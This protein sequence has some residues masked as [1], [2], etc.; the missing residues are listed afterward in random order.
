[1]SSE[2]DQDVFEITDFT[3][4]S[5][6][7]RF[8]SRIEEVFHEWKLPQHNSASP[9]K[10][11]ELTEG[12]WLEKREQLMFASFQFEAVHH[13]LKPSGTT[14]LAPDDDNECLPFCLSDMMSRENDF[15][16]KAH[17]LVRWYGLREFVVIHPAKA[18]DAIMTE[19]R[20]KM[21][22]SSVTIAVNNTSCQVPVFVQLQ[23]MRQK[24]YL[25]VCEGGGVRTSFDMIHLHRPFP[26]LQH[27][28]GLLQ[29]FKGKMP[30]STVP[31]VTV[32]IRFTYVLQ[33]WSP[34]SWPQ[35]PPE[36]DELGED[37]TPTDIGRLPCGALEDPI[38]E[39]HLSVTWPCF[40]E[41]TIIDNDVHSDLNPVLSPKWSMRMKT[42]EK[43]VCSMAD[44][45]KEFSNILLG[46]YSENQLLGNVP[47]DDNDMDVTQALDKLA[48]PNVLPT[49]LSQGGLRRPS[50]FQ[51]QWTIS[52]EVL[53]KILQYIFPDSAPTPAE[54]DCD[55]WKDTVNSMSDIQNRAAFARIQRHL[56]TSFCI[57][58]P[59]S[60]HKILSAIVSNPEETH[61]PRVARWNLR[62]ANWEKNANLTNTLLGKCLLDLNNDKALDK[63]ITSVLACAN[64][65]IPKGHILNGKHFWNDK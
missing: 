21:L 7:E 46:Y 60:G 35:P 26:Q 24:Y 29:L 2:E 18:N 3:T 40:F 65:C 28:Q 51:D 44:Y 58:P 49:L 61:A 59:N 45:L 6:W 55:E 9:L 25:G 10:K 13:Y 20:T 34:C 22:L 37:I 19:D 41:N 54:P 5:E 4:A 15:P 42:S 31:P 47:P 8:I 53:I 38:L 23:Q 63:I 16:P 17:C 1:M 62:K 36:L 50:R 32:S 33:D 64:V 56:F 39:F 14:S 27:M 12:V 11:G 30:L 43:P 57:S 52:E 48:H